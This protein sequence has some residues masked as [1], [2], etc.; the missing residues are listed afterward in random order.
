M[1][2]GSKWAAIAAIVAIIV[3][4]I[5]CR[6]RWKVRVSINGGEFEPAREIIV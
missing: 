2:V 1:V 5:A 3:G 6:T 4:S